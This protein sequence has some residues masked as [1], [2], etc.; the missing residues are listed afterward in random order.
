MTK[1]D[2]FT[3]EV[4][5]DNLYFTC[6]EM[7]AHLLKVAYSTII[8][9]SHDCATGITDTRGRVVAQS[10]GTPG[11]FCSIPAAAKGMLQAYPVDEIHPGDVLM[12][13]DPWISAGHLPD[14]FLFTPFF[15][16][17]ELLAFLVTVAHHLDVGGKNPG[18]TTPDTTDI[19]QEG[20]QIPIVKLYEEGRRNEAL[21]RLVLQNIRLPEVVSTD[22]QGQMAVN[23]RGRIRL[24]ELAEKF[25]PETLVSVFEETIARSEALTRAEIARMPDGTYTAEDWVDDDGIDDVPI[26]IRVAV[27]IKGDS[28]VIDF[29]GTGPEAKG[30]INTTPPYRDAYT[31]MI[32]RCFTNPDIPT[33]EGCYIPVEIKAP[34]GSVLNPRY[35]AAVAGRVVCVPRLSDVVTAA[36]SQAVPAKAM[37]GYGG[38]IGQPVVSGVDPRTG[39]PFIYM[40]N[41]HGGTGGRQ[42]KDGVDC[43][44]WPYNGGNHS[45]EV[46]ET[47]APVEVARYQVHENSEG[48][49]RWRGGL[50]L[51]KDYKML[52]Q[53]IE[54]HNV[55]DRFKFPPFG[56]SGGK[57]AVPQAYY[58]VRGGAE[59]LM[60]SKAPYELQ[61]GDILSVRMPGG[62][63][64]GDPLLRA[65]S[66]VLNDVIDGYVSPERA[67]SE[68]GVVI[69]P[70][71]A[72]DQPATDALRRERSAGAP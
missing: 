4:L 49:G 26:P 25:G 14:L 19:F 2:G 40:D 54:V 39:K 20:I 59:T 71:G 53:P 22:I 11:H 30:G 21:F 43:I 16:D 52:T 12:T 29:A 41:S 58:L 9:E 35:P 70:D 31:Q 37:A 5:R 23:E 28:M 27:T 67:R 61:T 51:I 13:N 46:L 62:G 42:G 69:G 50:G 18:S 17:G 57:A 1:P 66:L 33:N 32:V 63:G 47:I 60:K 6:E 48:P 55:G 45:I 65:P 36:L 15:Y 34:A 38:M 72:V 64:L 7:M 56:W 24:H 3:F 10:A 44:S 8:R 68:Y